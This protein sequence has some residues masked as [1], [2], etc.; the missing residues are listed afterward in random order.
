MS[1]NDHGHS[2]IP[3]GQAEANYASPRRWKWS[4]N[5]ILIGT[6]QSGKSTLINRFRSLAIGPHPLPD[7]AKVGKGTTSCTREP[8]LYEFDIPMSDFVLVEGPKCT[9]VEAPDDERSIFGLGLWKRK[10]LQVWR[11]NPHADIAR[12]RLLDT[13]GLDDSNPGMNAKNIEEVLKKLSALSE[14]ADL[15]M[16]HISAVMFVIKSGASFNDSLQKWYHHY[17]RCMPNLFGSIAVINTNYKFKDWKSEYAKSAL[18]TITFGGVKLSSRERKMK[19]R[20]EAWADIFHSDPTHFFIDSKPTS[21]TAFHE[22][23]SVNT[24]YDIMLYLRSQGKLPIENIR[25][26][27]L[28]QMMDID[29][30]VAGLLYDVQCFWENEKEQLVQSMTVT[31]QSL[32][33]HKKNLLGWENRVEELEKQLAVWDSDVHFDLNT[34]S[35]TAVISTPSKIWKFAT[36]SGHENCFEIKEDPFPFWVNAPDSDDTTWL[37]RRDAS[38]VDK[39]WRG[40]YKSKWGKMPKFTARSYTKSSVHYADKIMQALQERDDLLGS[41]TDTAKIIDSETSLISQMGDVGEESPRLMQL[42]EWLAHI[43]KLIRFLREEEVLLSEGF[44]S[45]AIARYGKS[46]EEVGP[47]EVLKFVAEQEPGLTAALEVAVA[48]IAKKPPRNISAERD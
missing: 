2:G 19:L 1:A 7:P 17:Q 39:T 31:H 10:D 24:V 12:L 45:S 16:R 33:R 15:E 8:F 21:E 6:S 34:Y 41:I 14:S 43:E 30:H 25:L 22:F 27:K 5:V 47:T 13:P 29:T 48:C 42:T 38:E 4:V 18:E 20:R 28:P 23:V 9:P 26:V 35:P 44:T 11:R 46:I 3:N 40:K 37:S 36:L 32:A